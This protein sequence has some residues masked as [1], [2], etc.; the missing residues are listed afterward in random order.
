VRG[1]D[2]AA[3]G[4]APELGFEVLALDA[5]EAEALLPVAPDVAPT[6]VPCC[7]WVMLS[8]LEHAAASETMPSA[9]ANCVMRIAFRFMSVPF[10]G[11]VLRLRATRLS[12]SSPLIARYAARR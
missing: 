12:H 8:K 7:W 11:A 4:E 9:L 10:D 2:E 1:L 5:L 3:D 6:L